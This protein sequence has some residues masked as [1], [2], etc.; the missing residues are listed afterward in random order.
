MYTPKLQFIK[1]RSDQMDP[2]INFGI[3]SDQMD[4][5]LNFGI[6][7]VDKAQ[8]KMGCTWLKRYRT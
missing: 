6:I 4:P 5:I 7:E 1:H 2:T 3:R 8:I